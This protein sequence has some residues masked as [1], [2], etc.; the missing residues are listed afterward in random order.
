LEEDI[1]EI[2]RP[3][4]VSSDDSRQ[5]DVTVGPKLMKTLLFESSTIN[6]L[7]SD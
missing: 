7:W 5:E 1:D 3:V 2:E 6:P 4:D